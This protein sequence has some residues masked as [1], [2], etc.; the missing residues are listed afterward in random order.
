VEAK[1]DLHDLASVKLATEAYAELA[2]A[3]FSK[4][5]ADV[6]PEAT[7]LWE[8]ARYEI[9]E[10]LYAE[11]YAEEARS[12]VD[13]AP[14]NHPDDARHHRSVRAWVPAWLWRAHVSRDDVAAVDTRNGY[15]SAFF[16]ALRATS[17]GTPPRAPVDRR[18]DLLVAGFVNPSGPRELAEA[19]ATLASRNAWHPVVLRYANMKKVAARYRELSVPL[20]WATSLLSLPELGRATRA[21]AA[22]H[23]VL[24]DAKGAGRWRPALRRA[25]ATMLTAAKLR[26]AIVHAQGVSKLVRDRRGTLVV[27][28][29]ERLLVGRASALAAA[30]RGARVVSVPETLDLFNRRMPPWG[31]LAAQRMYATSALLQRRLARAGIAPSFFPFRADGDVSDVLAFTSTEARERVRR[32]LALPDATTLVTY[33]SQGYSAD[34]ILIPAA[35][36]AA[37]A[38]PDSSFLVRPHPV[39]SVRLVRW[40][41]PGLRVSREHP[42]LDVLLASDAV[43]THSSFMAF[44]AA[45][46]GRPV[47]LFDREPLPPFQVL[48]ESGAVL[49]ARG[50]AQLAETLMR[51]LGSDRQAIARAQRALREDV[52]ALVERTPLSVLLGE[53]ERP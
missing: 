23:S 9:A 53:L 20:V 38:L 13:R 28:P 11:I 12:G 26:A 21:A 47:I 35:E 15:L 44:E 1:I 43:V 40:L 42:P 7:N 52:A 39:Q 17:S 50:E 27:V 2:R 8:A 34:R 14:A 22:S 41:A 30:A 5:L 6:R 49:R 37:A 51:A 3:D 32:E 31:A 36:R 4:R 46:L 18:L 48:L 19:L 24:V 16:S 10:E 45:L 25:A 33:V 29:D